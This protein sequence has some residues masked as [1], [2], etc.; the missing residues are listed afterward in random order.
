MSEVQEKQDN[1]MRVLSIN[2]SS[3]ASDQRSSL[4]D[5]SSIFFKGKD[6]EN[7]AV[8]EPEIE[9]PESTIPQEKK[10]ISQGKNEIVEVNVV[11][12]CL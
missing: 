8:Q 7:S 3:A 4:S 5:E 6:P 12:N 1:W 9:Q 11:V 10:V 2:S